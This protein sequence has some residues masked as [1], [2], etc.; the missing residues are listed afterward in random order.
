TTAERY[1]IGVIL[2]L[3]GKWAVYGRR[4]LDGILLAS[5]IY[6]NS[7]DQD[8]RLFIEDSASNPAVAQHAVDTL[9]NE[10]KVVAII[11]PLYFKE[12]VAV[13][14]RSQQLGVM[15]LSLSGKEGISEKG[16][17]LFQNALTP[18]V[19][20]DSLLRYCINEKKF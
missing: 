7:R 19:Q 2:P 18:R 17:Y 8:F 20:M 12:A 15:N 9:F 11:G 10:D 16:A 6:N 1:N 14:E 3:T 13:A 4:A 5:R